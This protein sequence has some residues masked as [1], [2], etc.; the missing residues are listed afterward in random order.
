M[1]DRLS[2]ENATLLA[3]LARFH[4]GKHALLRRSTQVFAFLSLFFSLTP[5]YALKTEIEARGGWGWVGVG[6]MLANF[7]LAALGL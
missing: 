4:S 7:S 3:E 5:V 2:T 6:Q 1:N